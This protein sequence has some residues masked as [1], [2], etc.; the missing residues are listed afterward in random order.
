MEAAEL[1]ICVVS[2]NARER[3]ASVLDA[4]ER[5]DGPVSETLLVDSGSTDGTTTWARSRWPR[6]RVL[7]LAGNRGPGAARNLGFERATHDLVLFVDD[8]V[9]PEPGCAR[10]LL[11]GLRSTEATFAMPTVVYA[12]DGRPVHHMGARAHFVGVVVPEGAGGRRPPPDGSRCRRTE[13]LIT[14][15]FLADR[16]RWGRSPPFDEAFFLYQED[17]DLGLRARALGHEI[18]WVPEALALHGRGTPGLSPRREG[19]H[20]PERVRLQ[21]VNRWRVLLK[22]YEARTLVLLAP[23]LLLYELAQ[24]LGALWL[25]AAGAWARAA[26][27][28]L[29]SLPE[30]RVRRQEVQRA[31]RRPDRALLTGGRLPLEA[32][33]RARRGIR[34]F[35]SG[36]D[37]LLDGY[38]RLVRPVL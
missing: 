38:W 21:V 2:H 37:R 36:L 29:R 31:R 32:G 12:R 3:L 5:L 20:M 7:S 26:R 24:L 11:E 16:A 18:V 19:R 23:P 9:A 22:N 8:D 35:A 34:V 14:A 4:L 25:G 10:A 27:D 17:H 33:L 30:L 1:T 13:S 28:V 6:V 15:C